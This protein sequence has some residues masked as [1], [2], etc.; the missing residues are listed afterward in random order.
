AEPKQIVSLSDVDMTDFVSGLEGDNLKRTA[1]D[2][3]II[4]TAA[5]R[6]D[7]NSDVALEDVTTAIIPAPSFSQAKEGSL[8]ISGGLKLENAPFED[9][10]VQA[11]ESRAE[12]LGVNL[13]G[14]TP[15]QIAITPE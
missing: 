14:T 15:V 12:L 4:A 11:L 8:D 1:G 6:F 9:A 7:K 13:A 2:N 3:N 10:Q 5:S